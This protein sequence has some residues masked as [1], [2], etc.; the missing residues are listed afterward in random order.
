[1]KLGDVGV[2]IGERVS[3]ESV[4]SIKAVQGIEGSQGM[5]QSAN[6]DRS[7][8]TR[9]RVPIIVAAFAN[10]R[11]CNLHF[12]FPALLSGQNRIAKSDHED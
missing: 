1:M 8:P 11:A 4:Q 10:A 12:R 7:D 2:G 9:I 6:G 5:N 3:P